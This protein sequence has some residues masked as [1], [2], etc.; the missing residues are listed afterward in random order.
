MSI[1]SE[2]ITVTLNGKYDLLS[3]TQKDS[4]KKLFIYINARHKILDK[5][6]KVH[7][8]N[9][10]SSFEDNTFEVSGLKNQNENKF[11]EGLN[12]LAS[13]NPRVS[14]ST[15]SFNIHPLDFSK[16][17]WSVRSDSDSL[18]KRIYFKGGKK[19]RKNSKKFRGGNCTVVSSVQQ[20]SCLPTPNVEMYKYPCSQLTDNQFGFKEMQ[21]F[22]GG[23]KKKKQSNM[24]KKKHIKKGGSCGQQV[25]HCLGSSYAN[26]GKTAI[27]D[28]AVS[29]PMT[30]SE[31]AWFHRYSY[32][33]TPSTNEVAQPIVQKGGSYSLNLNEKIGGLAQVSQSYDDFAPSTTNLKI[34]SVNP[35]Q[36]VPCNVLNYNERLNFVG[37]TRKRN[38]K[39]NIKG[40]NAP[41]P[42]SFSNEVGNFSSD[43]LTH[44]FNC[45]QPQWSKDCA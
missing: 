11:S 6:V 16:G 36:N 13:M 17:L 5:D 44:K 34:T 24:S 8:Y 32:G 2:E 9:I 35:S 14:L 45:N 4:L 18:D 20:P 7:Y 29:D 23:S 31:V 33:A 30:G 12:E 27:S 26:L 43:M 3:S 42:N 37:G 39:K 19:I 22:A 15:I 10:I 28:G 21:G 41:F 1:F 38:S 40:G 25:Q